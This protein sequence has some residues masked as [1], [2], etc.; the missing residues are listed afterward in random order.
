MRPDQAYDTDIFLEK[1]IL[2]GPP[3]GNRPHNRL[4]SALAS[5]FHSR[6]LGVEQ[7][8]QT[9]AQQIEPQ[10]GEGDRPAGEHREPRVERKKALRLPEHEAPRGVRRLR[11]EPQ[12]R[13]ARLGQ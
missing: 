10:D 13:E 7:I 6:R 3:R 1:S 9:I 5:A 12:I 11:A 8:P 2:K 4:V